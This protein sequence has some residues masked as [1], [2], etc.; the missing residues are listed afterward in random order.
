MSIHTDVVVIGAGAA[1]LWAAAACARAGVET[2]LVEKTARVGTKILASGGT[3]CNLTTTLRPQE[4]ARLFGAGERFV[5]PALKSLPPTAVRRHFHALGVETKEEPELEKV[6]PASDRAVDVR[7][8]LEADAR[9]WGVRFV[10]ERPVDGIQPEGERWRV[11]TAE[12]DLR[13]AAVIVCVGGKSYPKSGTTGDGYGWLRALGLTVVDPV[14]ALVP[15]RSSEPW[16]HGLAGIAVDGE[17]RIGSS[18]RRR[19]ALFTHKGLSG[20]GPMDLSEHVAR[21]SGPVELRIDLLPD[22][23]W[24]QVR[25]ELVSAAGRRGQP[26][27][28]RLFELPSRVLER[29][30]LRA[31]ATMANPPA[32]A[33]DRALRH[34][35]VNA[36]KGLPVE[37]D[38][39]M[40]FAKAEV[41]AG[42]L[43]LSLVDRKTMGVRGHPG[44]FVTGE[45]LDL[46]GPIG[47]L[48]FQAAFSTAALAARAATRGIAGA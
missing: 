11:R 45:L 1:G 8:A 12:G 26:R 29:V 32:A 27:L 21:A 46:Q 6:F 41:T 44:L 3:R 7:D 35:I 42:G 10:M 31:G 47:G 39:T 34:R 22:T 28:A 38:G 13:A 15:L 40:G 2:F 20:P 25:D 23:S 18:R 16:V 24:E 17:V 43:D 30:A 5:L 9:D 48:N 19:P 4:A 14:P 33:L 37:V 36:L